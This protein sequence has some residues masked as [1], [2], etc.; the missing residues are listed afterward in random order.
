MLLLFCHGKHTK[1]LSRDCVV[2]ETL[3]AWTDHQI[4]TARYG[5]HAKCFYHPTVQQCKCVFTWTIWANSKISWEDSQWM[6]R[7]KSL[8]MPNNARVRC[9]QRWHA[10]FQGLAKTIWY[11]GWVC[12]SVTKQNLCVRFRSAQKPVGGAS[13]VRPTN[14]RVGSD[15]DLTE[16]EPPWPSVGLHTLLAPATLHTLTHTHTHTLTQ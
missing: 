2:F 7:S 8:S 14:L 15:P 3:Q 1:E 6:L 5:P 13:G 9:T 10:C 16:W 4:R 12:R 11:Y